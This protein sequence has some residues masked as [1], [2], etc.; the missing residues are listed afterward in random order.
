MEHVLQESTDIIAL[1][2]PT[3]TYPVL[4]LSFYYS[5]WDGSASQLGS[6]FLGSRDQRWISRQ[7][8]FWDRR[9]IK[10]S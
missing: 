1:Y 2:A 3:T 5:K 6:T 10:I 4:P 9:R 7:A 8:F